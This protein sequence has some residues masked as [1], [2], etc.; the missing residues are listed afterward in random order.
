V[1]FRKSIPAIPKP[2]DD[3]IVLP[4]AQGT[5]LGILRFP[6]D[7]YDRRGQTVKAGVYTLRYSLYPVDGAHQGVAPQRDFAVLTPLAADADPNAMPSFDALVDAS[8][9][10]VEVPHPAILSL[11]A[12]AG[13]TLPTVSKEGD[14]DWVLKVKAGNVPIGIIIVGKVEG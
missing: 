10:G 2:A 7:G 3:A 5:L 11:E 8:I 13:G 1:W 12:P 6:S 14:S 9:K 4:I